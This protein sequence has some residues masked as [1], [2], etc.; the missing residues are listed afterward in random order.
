MWP[1]AADQG[2]IHD[3]IEGLPLYFERNA[4]QTDPQVH[5]LSHAGAFS[6]FLTETE[7]VLVLAQE[8]VMRKAAADT[9]DRC[10]AAP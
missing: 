8:P 6:L 4:G 10:C 1:A 7:A 9:H 5:F 3:K 2:A